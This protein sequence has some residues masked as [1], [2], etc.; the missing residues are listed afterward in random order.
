MSCC[1][2][3][4]VID[5]ALRNTTSAAIRQTGPRMQ[6]RTLTTRIAV[7]P[8]IRLG[9]RTIFPWEEMAMA[10]GTGLCIGESLVGGGNEV[11][12]IDLIMGPRGS[13]AAAAF[14]KCLTNNKDGFTPL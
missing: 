3:A 1:R 9:A 2:R 11:A 8:G 12:H 4:I 14:V 10:K 6:R 13:S 7:L 5:F